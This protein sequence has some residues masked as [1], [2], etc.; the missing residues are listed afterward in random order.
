MRATPPKVKVNKPHF[1]LAGHQPK[2]T[3]IDPANASIAADLN[4]SIPY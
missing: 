4:D 2:D 1:T 3:V